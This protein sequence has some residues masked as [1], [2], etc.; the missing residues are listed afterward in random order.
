MTQWTSVPGKFEGTMDQCCW[1]KWYNTLMP[2][3]NK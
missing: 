2:N 1:K 3:T